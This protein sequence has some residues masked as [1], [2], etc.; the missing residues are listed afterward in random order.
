[1]GFHQKKEIKQPDFYLPNEWYKHPAA[2]HIITV[3]VSEICDTF[4]LVVTS[5]QVKQYATGNGQRC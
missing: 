3:F 5:S 4:L 2:C 1:M